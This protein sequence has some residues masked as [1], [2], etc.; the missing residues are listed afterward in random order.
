MLLGRLR[1][2][3]KCGAG[4]EILTER[5]RERKTDELW[6]CLERGYR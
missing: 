4:N 6:R 5:Y 2:K 1:S 3:D